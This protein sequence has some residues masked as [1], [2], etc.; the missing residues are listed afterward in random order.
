MVY[1]PANNGLEVGGLRFRRVT[2]ERVYVCIC[3]VYS[4]VL[5]GVTNCLYAFSEEPEC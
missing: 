5:L 3:R 1:W 4:G 2:L